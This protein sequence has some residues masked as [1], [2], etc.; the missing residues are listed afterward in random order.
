LHVGEGLTTIG[1][2][3]PWSARSAMR[4]GRSPSSRDQR[5]DVRAN[6]RRGEQEANANGLRPCGRHDAC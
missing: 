3:D 4:A 2:F 5:A 1:T 6:H